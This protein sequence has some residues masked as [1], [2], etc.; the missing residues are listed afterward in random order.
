MKEQ[1]FEGFVDYW[2]L[3]AA[4]LLER[5]ANQVLA[6]HGITYRQVQVLG[7]LAFHQPIAQNQLAE[8]VQVEASTVVRI[9]DRMERDG[10]IV[11]ENDP[12]D[13][14]KKLI[15]STA[16]VAP[17]W[18]TILSVGNNVRLDGPKGLTRSQQKQLREL[19]EVVVR[20]LKPTSVK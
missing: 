6:E 20:N 15:R 18:D 11:R 2:I 14:R 19:L 7:A 9:L 16:K 4:N 13:R 3:S 8:I 1:D 17:I 10:W 12:G 5:T